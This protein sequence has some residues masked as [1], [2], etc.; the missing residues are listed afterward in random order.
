MA[1]APPIAC[2]TGWAQALQ[3]TLSS[4]N[5]PSSAVWGPASMCS[6]LMVV[7]FSPFLA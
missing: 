7:M 3:V 2:P 6:G 4:P 1:V 5:S